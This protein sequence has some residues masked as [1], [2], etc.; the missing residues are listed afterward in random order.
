[1]YYGLR[2]W[3]TIRAPDVVTR[4]IV[5]WGAA[6]HATVVADIIRLRGE[7][8]IAGFL[9]DTSA[10]RKGTLFCG[11]EVLGG[12]EELSSLLRNG[13]T[14]MVVAFG[15]CEG[16]VRVGRDARALGFD[17]VTVV[18][19]AAVVASDATLDSGCVVAA[20][21]VINPRTLVGSDT[22]INTGAIVEHDCSI[23]PGAHVCPGAVLGG[24]VTVGRT[25]WIGI[26]SV[27]RDRIQ[28]GD[29]AFVGAGAVVVRDVS[30]GDVVYGVPA[31]VRGR[32][33]DDD[34]E[35]PE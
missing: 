16:R 35:Q 25:A 17:L 11:A 13:V 21:A 28:I 22:I 15:D 31:R 8:E 2:R 32:R 30:A 9:D 1:L 5:I 7:F 6:G 3:R 27:V 18:H 10:T 26:G 29:G 19:P 33:R 24:W 34:E 12:R 23:L 14:A 4:K 20:R